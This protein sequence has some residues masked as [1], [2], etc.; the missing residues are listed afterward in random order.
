MPSNTV[1]NLVDLD[2][3]A[4]KASFITY[5]QSQPQFKGYDFV[6]QGLNQ[7]LDILSVNTFRNVFFLNMAISEGFIDSAQRRTSILSHAKELNYLPGSAKSAVANVTVT[8]TATGESQPYVIPK[9]AS[10]SA[11]IKNQNYIFS[12]PETLTCASAN[13][14]FTFTTPI[15]E[16]SYMN[17]S[18]IMNGSQI[19]PITFTISNPNID[20]NSLVVN[21]FEDDS[22]IGVIYQ[23]VSSLLGLV[24][25]SKVYFIQTNAAT[26]NYEILFGDGIAG[27]QPKSGAII[28]LDYRVTVGTKSNGSALFTINFDPTF[29]NGELLTQIQTI[30]NEIASGGSPPQTLESIRFYAPRYFQTQERAIVP[31][32]YEILL[33]QQFPEINAVNAYG[34]ETLSPPQFG[35][36]II[37]LEL[38]DIQGLP[39]SKIDAYTTFIQPRMSIPTIPI[40][41][42]PQFTYIQ[43]N[44][45]VRY[46][47]NITTETSNRISTL[48]LAGISDYNSSILNNFNVTFRFSQFT[49]MIDNVDPSIISNITKI[50]LYQKYIPTNG[51][52][53][54]ATFNF[55]LPLEN[56]I[57]PVG[58]TFAKDDETVLTSSQFSYQGNL[59][60][61]ADD[62]NGNVN[63]VQLQGSNY[64]ILTTIGTINY[65][66]GIVQLN[67][68]NPDSFVGSNI[69]IYV[70]PAD[71]D[72]SCQQNTILAIEPSQINITVQQLQA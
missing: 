3:D 65:S 22:Q 45:I 23:R 54:N 42:S 51:I 30:T 8:F 14:T 1:I 5:L 33:I 2:F 21:V 26:G 62:G 13:S 71:D 59:C 56:D 44:T 7:L 15:Y 48:V 66:T 67:G 61:F 18:Y 70:I 27:Y 64:V 72:V 4:L 36:V 38:N 53:Q 9:G 10:F 52:A 12:V 68:F 20:I 47:I 63:I 29:P 11:Q 34:G 24:E 17:D 40:F 43:V 28:V 19:T 31:Q 50:S 35:K 55:A 57:P 60:Q 37:A 69:Y 25:T 58:T 41:I 6:G 16:G 39:Q 32:D 49:T 46:N